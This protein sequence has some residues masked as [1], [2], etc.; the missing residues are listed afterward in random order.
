MSIQELVKAVEAKVM[1]LKDQI[2]EIGTIGDG[3][4]YKSTLSTMMF[5]LNDM[6][7]DLGE[8]CTILDRE[9]CGHSITC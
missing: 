8:T 3:D 4:E 6:V 7:D 5:D 1:D 9:V 2:E